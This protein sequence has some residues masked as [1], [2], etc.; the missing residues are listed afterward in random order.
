MVIATQKSSCK[1]N[2][3]SPHFLIVNIVGLKTQNCNKN[4][5]PFIV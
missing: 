4:V 5:D 2:C 1:A 3:K